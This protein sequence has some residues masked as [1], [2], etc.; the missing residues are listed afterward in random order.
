MLLVDVEVDVAVVITTAELEATEDET[1]EDEVAEDEAAED[2][3]AED[4][5]AVED[6]ADEELTDE[7]AVGVVKVEISPLLLTGYY[8][9][10]LTFAWTCKRTLVQEGIGGL[11]EKANI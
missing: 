3:I 10:T 11:V 4:E 9:H 1:A 6:A 7:D 5:A 8:Q 2:E